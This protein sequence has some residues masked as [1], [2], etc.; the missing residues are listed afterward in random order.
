[1]NNICGLDFGTSNTLCAV[2]QENMARL[3]PLE[4]GNYSIP[5]SVFYQFEDIG[6]PLYGQ[7]A[8]QTYINGGYGRYMKSFK[9]ILGTSI[10]DEG[11]LL[12]PGMRLKFHDILVDY[13]KNVKN[14]TESFIQDDVDYVVVGKPVRLAENDLNSSLGISQLKSVLKNVGYKDYSFLDEPI[15]AA[16]YHRNKMKRNS[17]ALVADLGGGTCDFTVVQ[18]TE[19]NSKKKLNILSTSGISI[20]GTDIDSEFALNIFYPELG[21]KTKDRFKGLLLPDNVYRDASDWNKITTSLYTPKVMMRIKK[22]IGL[23]LEKDK[24]IRFKDIVE[25][26]LAHSLLGEIENTKIDL[27]FKEEVNFHSSLLNNEKNYNITSDSLNESI[28]Y[29]VKKIIQKANECVGL[30]GVGSEKIEYLILT[31][32]TSKLPFL[33]QL[34][35]V[36]FSNAVIIDSNSMDSVC[37]GLLEKAKVDRND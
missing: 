7:L 26:K 14:K 11:T 27:S 32:G 31:G 20:G 36:T 34:L 30:S 29:L 18:I 6:N 24:V 28:D 13:L 37:L 4:E 5:S 15:A 2:L 12:K 9:R 23:A 33:R 21:Y 25:K 16:F 22:M 19:D 10:F 3:V 17:L 1:M 8:T 35:C